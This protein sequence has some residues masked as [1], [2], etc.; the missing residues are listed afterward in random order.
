MKFLRKLL[1]GIMGFFIIAIIVYLSSY[2]TV[3]DIVQQQIVPATLASGLK[4]AGVSEEEMK[5]ID[6]AAANLSGVD[7]VVGAVLK[8]V[9]GIRSGKQ[10]GASDESIDA[11]IN[12]IKN[13]K[14]FIEKYSNEEVDINEIESKRDEFK[15]SLNNL[16]GNLKVRDDSPISKAVSIMGTLTVNATK[17]NLTIILVILIALTI[18]VSWSYTLW[19]QLLGKNLVSAGVIDLFMYLLLSVVIPRI[20]VGTM[21]ITVNATSILIIAISLIVSGILMQ[22]IYKVLDKKLKEINKPMELEN[23]LK[24]SEEEN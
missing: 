17:K 10:E 3:F 23:P 24:P 1:I 13:N 9:N 14:N 6:E 11:I 22:I 16:Y 18:V 19:I 21:N 2:K 5:Q 15:T 20:A 4:D 12:F 7:E 8:D